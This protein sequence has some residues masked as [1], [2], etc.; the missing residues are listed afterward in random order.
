MLFTILILGF[1]TIF[2]IQ[3][4]QR[5]ISNRTIGIISLLFP[6]IST[7][8][9][10]QV[11]RNTT[12][13]LPWMPDIGL[14][15]SFQ[16]D[17]LSYFFFLLISF[18]SILVIFYSLF[19]MKKYDRHGYFYSS[20]TLFIIAMYGVVLSNNTIILYL[21][22]E[23][24]S[25]AS[26]L[27]IAF[28]FNKS[29]SY[30]GALKSFVITVIGGSF[31][32]VGFL[33]LNHITG[34]AQIDQI[35]EADISQHP[36]FTLSMIL[37]FI[38]AFS[39]SAQFPFH[40]WLPDAMEAP[41]PVSA[42]LHSATMVKAGVYLLIKLLPLYS[43]HQLLAVILIT[44]GVITM[45]MGSI[46]A[47]SKHDL[48][49]LLAYS[50][51]SQLGMMVL[52]VGI[53]ALPAADENIKRYAYNGLFLLILSHACYKATLFMGTGIIDLATGTRDMNKLSGLRHNLPITFVTMLIAAL[54]MAGLPFLSGFLSKELLITSLFEL[55]HSDIF[56][57]VILVLSI[58]ASIGTFIYC[59][60][61]VIRPFLGPKTT[62]T[63]PLPP[64]IDLSSII[65]TVITLILFF[66]PN[67]VQSLFISPIRTQ[68][69]NIQDKVITAWHGWTVPLFIT[70]AI[71]TIGFIVIKT[72]SY[73]YLYNAFDKVALNK[74]YIFLG[75]SKEYIAKQSLS[76]LMTGTL[77]VYAIYLYLFI[78]FLTLPVILPI[79]NIHWTI[80][81]DGNLFIIMVAIVMIVSSLGLLFVKSRMTAVVMIGLV[82]YGV[83]IL[84]MDMKAPD[85][86]L[87]QLVIET[88]TTVLFLACFYHLP[89]LKK[90]EP[91]ITYK[92][93]RHGIAF[94]IA[95]LVFSVMI[96]SQH[97]DA[98]AT[99]STYY[100]NSYQLT[101]AKNVVNAILGDFRAFDTMLEGVVIMI[102]GFGIYTILKKGASHEGK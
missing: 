73:Q 84:F 3:V 30:A 77:N 51:I 90:E 7:V 79:Q 87:T 22:W 42:L 88:I 49:A 101:G 35:L 37:I 76:I 78:A 64:L 71:F 41:T 91:N 58:I 5:Y 57:T 62:Q 48:K 8:L 36:L 89:N 83:S 66:I 46:V 75:K 12:N 44:A 56:I 27:L 85:L 100:N 68:Q 67:N 6:L 16:L 81:Y 70:I 11:P 32:L 39:K 31:M 13:T 92:L 15:F 65:L 40:I 2:L 74:A 23:L 54:A 99:I 21:F 10:F 55:T 26:F 72:R 24:T 9:I 34:T 98:F 18:I 33:L 52:F 50:T 94:A 61:L 4:L 86:A 95:A 1:V 69:V 29:A 14:Y 47:I 20:L 28:H 63:K 45:L 53:I 25:V 97:I 19:Y 59:F 96:Q 43:G 80:K 38:G 60:V 102:V 93:F 82:G 17:A